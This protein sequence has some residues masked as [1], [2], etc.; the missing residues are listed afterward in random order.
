MISRPKKSLALLICGVALILILGLGWSYYTTT[1]NQ[2]GGMGPMGPM[3]V[4]AVI[5]KPS[6]FIEHIQT[7][8]TLRSDESVIIRPE[9][10]GRIQG[11]HFNEGQ[12]VKKGDVLITLDP[13]TA[14]AALQDAQAAL[15]L[16]AANYDRTKALYKNRYTSLEKQDKMRA[17]Y[18]QAESGLT[19]RTLALDKM[20][21]YAPFDGTIGF[22]DVSVGDYVQPGQ[23]IVNL[24]AI[25]RL[26]IDF[27]L[28]EK[29]ISRVQIGQTLTLKS[30]SMPGESLSGV[31][32][33]INPQLEA[34]GRH[35]RVRG[36]VQ[37]QNRALKPGMFVRVSLAVH[38][39]D[40]ALMTPEESVIPQGSKPFIYTIK[41]SKAVLNPV[42][43]GLRQDG[44]VQVLSGIAPGDQVITAGQMK[45]RPSAPVRIVPKPESGQ[46]AARP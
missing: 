12:D 22:R 1:K 19:G 17:A 20:T 39:Y 29:D 7:V 35:V 9:V 44:L 24:E 46:Q 32:Y 37:N 43:L 15:S 28:P 6:I 30:D 8:G 18:E 45:L 42:T 14:Q 13:R 3:P 4:E 25:D 5:V 16:N 26:K 33:A 23:D 27:S 10:S 40:G 11:I 34:A 21:L 31:I 41:D 2:S 38:Q 36:H